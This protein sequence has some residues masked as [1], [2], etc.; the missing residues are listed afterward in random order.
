MFRNVMA[1]G[2]ILAMLVGAA[3][4]ALAE[5]GTVVEV[6]IRDAPR[7]AEVVKTPFYKRAK[8]V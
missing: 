7:R 1:I 8:K 4:P 6:A 3:P 2:G 5:P